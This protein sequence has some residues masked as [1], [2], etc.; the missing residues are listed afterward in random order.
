MYMSCFPR[1][2]RLS[3]S[4]MAQKRIYSFFAPSSRQA[5]LLAE[6]WLS[7]VRN[8]VQSLM[9][10]ETDHCPCAKQWTYSI[11]P[12]YFAHCLNLSVQDVTKQ[13][14]LL[15][16]CMEII[17]QLVQLIIFFKNDL[18]CLNECASRSPWPKLINSA[19]TP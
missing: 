17:F 12:L 3:C 8:G 5:S 7:G 10:K 4:D 2:S 13:C 9:K 6:R 16:D 15:R 18:A 1:F 19:L 14:E 11:H